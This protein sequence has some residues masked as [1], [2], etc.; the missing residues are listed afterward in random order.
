MARQLRVHRVLDEQVVQLR[1]RV[2]PVAL[3]AGHEER[4]EVAPELAQGLE[5]GARDAMAE[6]F[7]VR[8]ERAQPVKGRE[9][10]AALVPETGGVHEPH[11]EFGVGGEVHSRFLAAGEDGCNRLV[12]VLSITQIGP[13]GASTTPSMTQCSNG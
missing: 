9:Q 4:P 3:R 8:H 11:R 13:G 5:V 10:V 1:C 7:P 6:M 2:R 12:P